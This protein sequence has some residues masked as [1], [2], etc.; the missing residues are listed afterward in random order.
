M[1]ISMQPL[2]SVQM[3][4]IKIQKLLCSPLT[5]LPNHFLILH[6][7]WRINILRNQRAKNHILIVLHRLGIE[8]YVFLLGNWKSIAMKLIYPLLWQQFNILRLF[9]IQIFRTKMIF[10]LTLKAK[11]MIVICS[12]RTLQRPPS[13]QKIF[14]ER[15][16]TVQSST[17]HLKCATT[18]NFVFVH[19]QFIPDVEEKKWDINSWWSWMKGNCHDSSRTIETF[20]R[21]R[22]F[23]SYSNF[24][25]SW[26]K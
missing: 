16:L 22:W 7:Y 14:L 20:E 23:Y 8:K 2:Q 17:G 10:P 13:S 15:F 9:L 25:L 26:Q 1:I 11:I 19:V 4:I 21:W 24:Y 3:P 18:L 6:R 5:A 12:F